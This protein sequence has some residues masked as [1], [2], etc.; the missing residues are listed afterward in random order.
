MTHLVLGYPNLSESVDLVK[1]MCGVGASIVELQIP[2]SDPIA[3]GQ[4]I[5][6]ANEAALKNGVKVKDCLKKIEEICRAV[7]VP[8]LIM[9]YYNP[10]YCYREKREQSLTAFC[11]HVSSIGVSGL[12]VPDVPPEESSE[13][14]WQETTR[15]GLVPVPIVSPVTSKARLKLLKQSS[16]KDGFVYCMSTTGV[17][18]ARAKLSPEL[19]SY[20][21]NVGDIF[22]LPLAVG[23]GLS[24]AQQLKSL[25][26]KAHIAIVGSAV[27]NKLNEAPNKITRL[28]T[29]E[30]FVN[31]LLS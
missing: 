17:T 7:D 6:A 3:D 15:W 10:L 27:I 23:F 1:A 4:T 5:M 24:T 12:I 11:K 25:K 28:K 21:K 18:G 14:Y 30:K 29:V 2:F 16:P 20:L 13:H 22:K 19:S 31:E 8:V 9:S 26:G